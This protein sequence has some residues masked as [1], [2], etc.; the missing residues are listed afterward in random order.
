MLIAWDLGVCNDE[1]F[2]V[3]VDIIF[4]NASVMCM[5]F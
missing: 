1:N 5:I 3:S 2:V 4:I